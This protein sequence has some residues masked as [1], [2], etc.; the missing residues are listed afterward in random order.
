MNA[1]CLT[2][3]GT[4]TV[5]PR[6]DAP[7][8]IVPEIG[9]MLL[10]KVWSGD[11]SGQSVVEMLT[12]MTLV[13]GSAVYVAIEVVQATLSGKQGR[14]AF[15]HAGIS[16]RGQQR[17]TY[18]VVPDSGSGELAGLSGELRLEIVE[19]VHRYT[20]TYALAGA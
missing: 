18:A 15:Y 8:P 6:A 17:L 19:K 10:D 2:A 12:F 16:E 1:E 9:R 14:F 13:E 4:F 7:A 3:T 11:L 20:L 5:R